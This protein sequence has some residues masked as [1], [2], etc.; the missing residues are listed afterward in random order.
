M[1]LLLGIIGG[2]VGLLLIEWFRR[3]LVGRDD[4]DE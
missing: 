3:I 1:R 4:E 2:F